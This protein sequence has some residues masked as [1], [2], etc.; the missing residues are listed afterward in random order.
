LASRFWSAFLMYFSA[1]L[2][3]DQP[4]IAISC[5]VVASRLAALVAP[6]LRWPKRPVYAIS[7]CPGVKKVA[8][9]TEHL[10]KDGPNLLHECDL[11]STDSNALD[12]LTIGLGASSIDKHDNG[13][14]KL[15]E[16][17]NGVTLEKI[18]SKTEAT[19]AVAL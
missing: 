1:C 6:A 13:R 18:I 17:A 2:G 12:P 10:A 14:A 19:F 5:F 11:P 15:I 4:K 3:S 7:R 8:E 9:V 16:L